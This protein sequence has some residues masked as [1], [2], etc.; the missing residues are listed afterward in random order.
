MDK[1]ITG[2]MLT[3]RYFLPILLA[4]FTATS[5]AAQPSM[6]FVDLEGNSH[7]LEDYR[8]KWVVI[9]YWAT[10]CPP[11]LEE[12]PELVHF[13]ES[14]KDDTAVVLGFNMERISTA[15]LSAFVEDNLITYPVVPVSEDV[16]PIG[17]IPGLPTT[18]LIDPTGKTV[19]MQVGQVTADMLNNY[20]ENGPSS[21]ESH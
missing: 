14:R 19:A 16:P 1:V 7:S 18:Y 21:P 12:L 17:A 15:S 9:N 20:I 3:M 4:I 13:H 11:C 8:G 5:I 2:Q 10:W 6:E